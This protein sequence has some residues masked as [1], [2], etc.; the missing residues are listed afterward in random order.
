MTA[1][2]SQKLQGWSAVARGYISAANHQQT[3]DHFHFCSFGE[4][5]AVVY[6]CIC[7][8]V[9]I[10]LLVCLSVSVCMCISVFICV[11]VCLSFSLCVWGFR[12]LFIAVKRY[13]VCWPVL[14]QLVHK[15]ESERKEPQLKKCPWPLHQLL[16]PGSCHVLSSC[17]DLL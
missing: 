17:H 8:C 9:C 4:I 6:R 10:C 15:L 2:I 11:S 12:Y 3:M 5:N 7:M 14:C 16:P 1:I 13:Y